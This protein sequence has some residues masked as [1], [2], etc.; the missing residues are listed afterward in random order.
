MKIGIMGGTFNP[1]HIAHIKA[2]EYAYENLLLDKVLVIPTGI[3][4][5]KAV[6]QGMPKP[7]QRAK[8]AELATEHLKYVE[9]CDIEIKRTGKSYSVD[10]LY[11]ISEQNPDAT[12]YFIMGTDMF[13]SLDTWHKSQQVMNLA[14]IVVIPRNF[15]NI[16]QLEQKRIHYKQKFDAKV[17]ILQ[18]EITELSSTMLREDLNYLTEMVNPKVLDYIKKNKLYDRGE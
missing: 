18:V 5:H 17:H 4:P 16:N 12:L 11:E 3:P 14:E 9:V 15:N 6:Y 2:I 7:Y 10:T 1:P 13:L 8:M